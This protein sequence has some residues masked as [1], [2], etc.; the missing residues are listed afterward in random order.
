MEENL[1]KMGYN[2]TSIHCLNDSPD[3]LH[4]FYIEYTQ[5]GTES[6][7]EYPIEIQRSYPWE[8][9]FNFNEINDLRDCEMKT[10]TT[11]DNYPDEFEVS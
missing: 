9:T 3:D 4:F 6:S 2:V 7:I 1:L 10:M 5:T 11:L 8:I